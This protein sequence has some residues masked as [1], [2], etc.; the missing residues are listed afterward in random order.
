MLDREPPDQTTKEGR[1]FNEGIPFLPKRKLLPTEIEGE[2]SF[3]LEGV[4]WIG[5]YDWKLFA[6][7][8]IGD[9]KTSSDPKRWGLTADKLPTNLQACTYVYDSGWPEA[10][11]RWLYYGKKSKSAYPVDAL[12]TREQATTVLSKFVSVTKEMQKWFNENPE[13][14]TVDQLNE[15]PNNPD[16]CDGVGRMC[17]FG[18]HCLIRKPLRTITPEQTRMSNAKVE[19]LRRQ[20]EERKNKGKSTAVNPPESEAAL[21]ETAKEVA[22][23]KTETTAQSASAPDPVPEKKDAEPKRKPG[24]PPTK[25]PEVVDDSDGQ[26]RRNS[27]EGVVEHLAA[28]ANIL[29]PNVRITIELTPPKAA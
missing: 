16:A 7:R 29:P 2:V 15:I 8:Q 22:G 14:L 19:E 27:I 6:E 1:L 26:P 21:E 28:L 4:P 18:E 10:N 9:H 20:I 17:D 23:E 13:K 3:T 5:Y 24:R 25:P 11:L 12:V